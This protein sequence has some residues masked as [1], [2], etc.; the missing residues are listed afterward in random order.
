M[1]T[2]VKGC[3]MKWVWQASRC[4]QDKC[5]ASVLPQTPCRANEHMELPV[6]LL[7]T[8]EAEQMAFGLFGSP[9]T[10]AQGLLSSCL[11]PRPSSGFTG[12]RCTACLPPAEGSQ[13]GDLCFDNSNAIVLHSFRR[14]RP[15]LTWQHM[16]VFIPSVQKTI[17][18]RVISLMAWRLFDK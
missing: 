4:L 8:S 10:S 14:A 6:S 11:Q 12:Q 2:G 7:S 9:S 17:A 3:G 1:K 16:P 15:S 5:W 18:D 13:P